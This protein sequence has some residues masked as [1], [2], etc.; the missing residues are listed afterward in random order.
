M[1]WR[2]IKRKKVLELAA[3]KEDKKLK[4]AAKLLLLKN[5]ET[6][7]DKDWVLTRDG[8]HTER[9]YGVNQPLKRYYYEKDMNI[10]HAYIQRKIMEKQWLVMLLEIFLQYEMKVKSIQNQDDVEYE[11]HLQ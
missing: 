7:K 6:G 5:R 8:Y 2:C 3:K 11:K 9:D 1:E 10:N 4:F